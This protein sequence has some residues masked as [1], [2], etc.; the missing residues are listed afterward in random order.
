MARCL[1]DECSSFILYS[2]FLQM[3][4]NREIGRGGEVGLSFHM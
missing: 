1:I 3:L 2:L 4:R